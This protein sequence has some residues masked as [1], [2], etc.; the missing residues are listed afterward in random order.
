MFLRRPGRQIGARDHYLPGVAETLLHE[1]AG[2][3]SSLW[4]FSGGDQARTGMWRRRDAGREMHR[5]GAMFSQV[6]IERRQFTL[7]CPIVWRRDAIASMTANALIF[8]KAN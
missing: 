6:D 4:G 2:G 5:H 8:A 3:A 1:T 7:R